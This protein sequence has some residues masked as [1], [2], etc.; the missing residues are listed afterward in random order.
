MKAIQKVLSSQMCL[1]IRRIQPLNIMT[2]YYLII[3][4]TYFNQKKWVTNRYPF[5]NIKLNGF[6]L[7]INSLLM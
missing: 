4:S 6:Y 1:K 5:L 7:A 2:N 3:R